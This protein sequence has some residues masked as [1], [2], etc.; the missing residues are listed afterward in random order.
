MTHPFF[1]IGHSTR[2]IA[3]FVELLRESEIQLVVDVR[4][5]PR[6]RT[7]P[8]FNRDMLPA[9]LSGFAI[10]YEHIAQLGGLRPRSLIVS[11]SLN[12]FWQNASFHN[13]A[14]YAMSED[15]KSGL[16]RL[17]ELGHAKRSAL[18]CAEAVW[19]RCH[20]RIIADYLLTAGDEVFHI[21]GRNHV[22]R[23]HMT[24]AAHLSPGGIL[25]YPAGP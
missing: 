12:A 23:A 21:L 1:T 2:S 20:R 4:T 10:D 16:M 6:S 11:T 15:F 7:N 17:R 18:M 3:E 8:Q 25:T 22:E 14:D 13:Y 19:W 5:V 24:P 9:T